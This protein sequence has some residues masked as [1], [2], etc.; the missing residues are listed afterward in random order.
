MIS[1][2]RFAALAGAA[3]VARTGP[4]RARAGVMSGLVDEFA[5]LEA[6]SGGR[7]GVA[8]LDTRDGGRVAHRGDERFPM[9]STF[10][11]LAAAAILARVD[12]GAERLDPRVR[13]DAGALVEVSPLTQAH[14]G[15]DGMSLEALCAAAMVYSDNTAA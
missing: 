15:G 2:R 14:V 5:R 12:A 6:A 3:L 13:L 7:L 1:R 10:K 9:S 8:V 4:W 11:L